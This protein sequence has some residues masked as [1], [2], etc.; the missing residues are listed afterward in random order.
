M[1]K[2]GYFKLGSALLGGIRTIGRALK[3][4]LFTRPYRDMSVEAKT[5]FDMSVV[6]ITY[7]NAAAETREVEP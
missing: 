2:L 4:R 1:A 6:A 7:R 3:P 5:Y